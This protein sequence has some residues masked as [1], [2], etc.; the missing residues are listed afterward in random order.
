MGALRKGA[1]SMADFIAF[2]SMGMAVGLIAGALIEAKTRRQ[3]V[4]TNGHDSN[5][6]T[7]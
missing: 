2:F 5:D 1:C 3:N 4:P 6:A 7:G